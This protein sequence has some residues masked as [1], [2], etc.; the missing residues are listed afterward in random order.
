VA[1]GD[2]FATFGP[3]WPLASGK[4]KQELTHWL[5]T[6]QHHFTRRIIFFDDRV[7][8]QWGKIRVTGEKTGRSFP[9]LDA[10]IGACALTHSLTLV[11]RNVSDF[12][13][14]G[15]EIINPWH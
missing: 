15:I 1:P 14:M 9:V 12:T 7:A 2:S 13:G 10:Q 6:M 11:T 4:R 3:C 5:T 8:L